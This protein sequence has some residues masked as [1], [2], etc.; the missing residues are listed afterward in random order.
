M[1]FVL[2]WIGRRGRRECGRLRLALTI[3]SATWVTAWFLVSLAWGELHGSAPLLLLGVAALAI[4]APAYQALPHEL[5]DAPGRPNRPYQPW[6]PDVA[7]SQA[8]AGP[9]RLEVIPLRSGS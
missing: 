7:R 3:V 2:A 6:V 8:G 5:G 1:L 4:L 9:R